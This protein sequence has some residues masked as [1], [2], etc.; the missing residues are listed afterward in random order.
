MVKVYRKKKLIF[1]KMIFYNYTKTQNNQMSI[2]GLTNEN[3]NFHAF[4]R[5]NLALLVANKEVYERNE[6]QSFDELKEIVKFADTYYDPEYPNIE[7][8]QLILKLVEQRFNHSKY[9][10]F[11]HHSVHNRNKIKTMLWI[12]RFHK[13]IH[14]LQKLYD[15]Y[16]EDDIM[17]D[18]KKR[19][20]ELDGFMEIINVLNSNNYW[21]KK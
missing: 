11:I 4:Q 19:Q 18:I 5:H 20:H 15:E 7:D 10:Y 8:P 13:I 9:L 21:K 2:T 3:Y 17:D 6:N 14:T 1:Q 16:Q 12:N